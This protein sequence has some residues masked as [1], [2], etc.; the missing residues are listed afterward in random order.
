VKLTEEEKKKIAESVAGNCPCPKSKLKARK[1]ARAA[2]TYKRKYPQNE[3]GRF[4]KFV[5]LAEAAMLLKQD[6]VWILHQ[7]K[8]KRIV[9]V[10]ETDEN[11]L[12]TYKFYKQDLSKLRRFIRN[13][14][15][16]FIV[17]KSFPEVIRAVRY[18]AKQSNK[19]AGQALSKELEKM[20]STEGSFTPTQ[21]VSTKNPLGYTK[22]TIA[23]TRSIEFKIRIPPALLQKVQVQLAEQNAGLHDYL[24]EAALKLI[25]HGYD[26]LVRRERKAR[27]NGKATNS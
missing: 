14:R 25:Q 12:T 2:N 21:Y 15:W 5:T 3:R 16:D 17:L 19:T 13:K 20:V 24:E 27:K 9:P 11:G 18:I 1:Y 6:P 10:V 22:T 8:A 7:V 4:A 23:T 26:N